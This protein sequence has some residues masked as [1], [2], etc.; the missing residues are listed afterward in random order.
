MQDFVYQLT[1]KQILEKYKIDKD[2]GLSGAEVLQSREEYGD[3]RIK[4][5]RGIQVL[6][7]LLDQFRNPLILILIISSLLLLVVEPFPKNLTESGFIWGTVL[8]NSAFGF[9]Q[10][11]KANKVLESL[12]EYDQPEV[13]VIREGDKKLVSQENV[14][15][16][17]I[18]LVR[19][20]DKVPA[21]GRIIESSNLSVSEAVLTGES[22][23]VDKNIESISGDKPIFERKNML[24]R[25]TTVESGSGLMLV[26]DVGSK[27]EIGRI[28]ELAGTI[29]TQETPLQVKM[30]KFVKFLAA[31]M[32]ILTVSVFVV[33]INQGRDFV[34]MFETGLAIVTGGIPEALP[35]VMALILAIGMKRLANKKGI[36]RKLS[37]VE[38]LGSTTIICCDKTKTLTTGEMKA[39]LF[40]NREGDFRF[41]SSSDSSN[42]EKEL[43]FLGLVNSGT[44]ENHTSIKKLQSE[45]LK[46]VGDSTDRAVARLVYEK[47]F[48]LD[49]VDYKN[50]KFEDYELLEEVEFDS[51]KGYQS[52]IY[53]KGET[54]IRIFLGMPEKL[55]ELD[56]QNSEF[57]SKKN[58]DLTKKGYRVI[59]L[60]VSEI[61]NISDKSEP[62]KLKIIGLL[63]LRNP[64]RR[65]VKESLLQASVAGA[66]VVMI[67]GDHPNTALSVADRLGMNVSEEEV[68]IGKDLEGLDFEKFKT[69]VHKYK[70]YARIK[71]ESKLK[72]VKAWQS[73]GEVVAMTGDGVN[74]GPAIKQA[75]IGIAVGSG[76]E[77]AKQSADLVLLNDSFNII[78]EAI[79]EGRKI[80]D[81][82]RKAT[83]YVLADSLASIVIVGLSI[84]TKLPLPILWQQ[85]LWNNI[86]EDS[87]PN[88]A[89]AFEKEEKNIL[90][91]QPE[92]KNSSLLTSPMKRMVLVV[93][94][95][96]QLATFGLFLVLYKLG[97]ELDY[98]RTMVFGS[99]V[100]DTA[101]VIYS[102][103][104]LHKNIWEYKLFDNKYLVASSVLVFVAFAAAL[105]V[106]FLS[107]LLGTV[108]LSLS[109]WGVLTL[110]S[111]VVVGM[112]E[113][114][115][116]VFVKR[117]L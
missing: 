65:G 58:I 12:E 97:F 3:N 103:K 109:D 46:L 4:K 107:G 21:D 35:V 8:I 79:K 1:P 74:D 7:I 11:F 94:V 54:L 113:F 44:I 23:S 31:L 82:I 81:N 102:F 45:E 18:V 33:G 59:A 41:N 9:W 116:F 78:V 49:G 13:L 66:K 90:E 20:G 77:V 89:F 29:D 72:I 19:S 64:L 105:Y 67:T 114:G 43:I 16:G 100:M 86:V 96:D 62:D 6:K 24:F 95:F 53:K 51:T 2:E 101:F 73:R 38:T 50:D 71:P 111:F 84:I 88:I 56:K 25:G 75:D 85:I 92:N 83:A 115:K 32:I 27:T 99:L 22:V 40:S 15:V 80:L 117:N 108:A 47:G 30:K 61:E 17:D 10:E 34:N 110:V 37:C 42:L 112:T 55:I 106:P 52:K 68:L 93:G 91:R 39:E 98:V 63:S 26:T 76:T 69:Q 36:V 28:A 87:F 57:Y 48:Y 14:V 70:I 104:N 5:S 60:A